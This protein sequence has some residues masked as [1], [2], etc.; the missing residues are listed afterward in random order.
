MSYPL[1][2]IPHPLAHDLVLAYRAIFATVWATSGWI[3]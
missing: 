3:A 2:L 1:T